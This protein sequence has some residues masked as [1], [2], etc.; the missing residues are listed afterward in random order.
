MA[1]PRV[2][3]CVVSGAFT[4]VYSDADIDLIV[5]DGDDGEDDV[6][7]VEVMRPTEE[8]EMQEPTREAVERALTRY[9]DDCVTDEERSNG[10][11]RT[12]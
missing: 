12:R 1:K 4:C 9:A 7:S 3:V 8:S 2:V 5:V 11:K 6:V 10:P